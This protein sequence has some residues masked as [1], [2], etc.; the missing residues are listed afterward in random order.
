M[1]TVNNNT[2]ST[3]YIAS[4]MLETKFKNIQHALTF[5]EYIIVMHTI[6]IQLITIQCQVVHIALLTLKNRNMKTSNVHQ[7]YSVDEF[8]VSKT[9][10]FS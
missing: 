8:L 5:I 7:L 1:D 3:N 4:F 2:M 6:C 9:D 10:S